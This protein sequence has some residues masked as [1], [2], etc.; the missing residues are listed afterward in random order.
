MCCASAHW[1]SPSASCPRPSSLTQVPPTARRGGLFC[2]GLA[3]PISKCLVGPIL[4][5]RFQLPACPPT[6]PALPRNHHLPL[7]PAAGH[8]RLLALQ[9]MLSLADVEEARLRLGALELRNPLMGTSALA[10][11]LQ[12]RAWPGPWQHR[13]S[14]WRAGAAQ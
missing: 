7:H 4:A 10:Q 12:A 5:Q 9:R 14:G 11:L 13:D 3:R 2:C 6:H 1:S 8:P